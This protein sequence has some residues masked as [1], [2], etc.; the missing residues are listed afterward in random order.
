MY[1]NFGTEED[2]RKLKS[3]GVSVK[4]K[5]VLVRQGRMFRGNKVCTIHIK[6]KLTTLM[7]LSPFLVLNCFSYMTLSP[8]NL[9]QFP[10][11]VSA[12]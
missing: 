1:V 6:T 3:M 5:I 4:N 8:Y 10:D 11:R 9:V 7:Y 12:P 2:F